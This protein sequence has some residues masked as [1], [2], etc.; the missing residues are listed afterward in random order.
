MR[1]E[2]EIWRTIV[3]APLYEISNLGRVRN[4][5]RYVKTANGQTRFY[6]GGLIAPSHNQHGHEKALLITTPGAK[7]MRYVHALVA[8]AFIGPRPDGMEVAHNDGNPRNNKVS[9]LRYATPV[10]N[11]A[12][13]SIHGTLLERAIHPAA[14]LTERDVDEIFRRLALKHRQKDIAADFGVK[15][16]TIGAIA[17]GR[18][19]RSG[20]AVKEAA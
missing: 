3:D 4:H 8:Q 15:R 5:D 7:I 9:N 1:D 17:Q 19:W 2:P 6:R 12:D 20:P 10:E 14:K 16:A 13:K 18:S 11:N